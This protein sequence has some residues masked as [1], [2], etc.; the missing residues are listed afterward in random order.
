M[1]QANLVNKTSSIKINPLFIDNSFKKKQEQHQH[2]NVLN[3][4]QPLSK[5]LTVNESTST[6]GNKSSPKAKKKTERKHRK[7]EN[8]RRT[9]PEIPIE[10]KE[11]L[12]ENSYRKTIT[13]P[14]ITQIQRKNKIEEKKWKN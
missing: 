5:T 13:K 10:I 12:I 9:I 3:N 7:S 14:P 11:A 6:R 8:T 4:G 2:N 1:S